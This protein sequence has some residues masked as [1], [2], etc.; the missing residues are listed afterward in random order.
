MRSRRGISSAS[1]PGSRRQSAPSPASPLLPGRSSQCVKLN[2]CGR[3]A[4]VVEQCP[5]KAWVAGSNPAALTKTSKH[6]ANL[7]RVDFGHPETPRT[8]EGVVPMS[9]RRYVSPS[10][11]L[12]ISSE[13]SSRLAGSS[14]TLTV[15]TSCLGVAPVAMIH[16]F[17]VVRHSLISW[18]WN[19]L[20]LEASS[21][22]AACLVRSQD[23]P[24]GDN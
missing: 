4:Q 8:I 5:F 21:G 24:V 17:F 11:A 10:T 2:D 7:G 20:G 23:Q 16:G 15:L 14:D 1:Q 6:L 9:S 22:R 13:A 19:L 18:A 12:E 3:V